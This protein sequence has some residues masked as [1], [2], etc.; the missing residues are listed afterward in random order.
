M[1][2]SFQSIVAFT[3]REAWNDGQPFILLF[4]IQHLNK[5]TNDKGDQSLLRCPVAHPSGSS[6]FLDVELDFFK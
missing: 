5:Q 3:C 2:H 4:F 1:K 6:A